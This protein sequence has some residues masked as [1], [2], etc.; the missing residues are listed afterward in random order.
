[1]RQNIYTTPEGERVPSFHTG[2]GFVSETLSGLHGPHPDFLDGF[3]NACDV[4][5]KALT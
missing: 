2:P 1:V 5:V 3:Q 4:I